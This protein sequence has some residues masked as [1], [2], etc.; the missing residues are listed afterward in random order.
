MLMLRPIDSKKSIKYEKCDEQM[1][2][3]KKLNLHTGH[4]QRVKA[5]YR[6]SGLEGFHDHEVLELLLYYCYSRC[7][8]NEI[9]HKMLHEFGSLH[10]LFEADIEVIMDRLGCTENVAILLNLIPALASKYL[11]SRWGKRI[12]LNSEKIAAEYVLGLFIGETVETF[13]VLCLDTQYKLINSTLIGKG[14]I[15]EIATYPREIVR[16]AINNNA[17]SVILAHNHP[18]GTMRPSSGDN[19]ATARI[20]EALRTIDVKITDHIIAAGDRYFSYAA[21]IDGRSAMIAGYPFFL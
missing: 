6:K 10:H 8:T 11:V 1:K 21:R 15:S 17:A 18:G 16:V 9:A 14:T 19:E 12:F 2:P 5:K 13:Y 4:R 20:S 3:P 7:D